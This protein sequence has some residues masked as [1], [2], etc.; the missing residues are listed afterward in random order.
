MPSR[1]EPLAVADFTGGLNLGGDPFQLAQNESPDLLNVEL[2]SQ[3]GLRSREGWIRWNTSA[4]TADTWT[5]KA[6]RRF[7]AAS[8]NRYVML[9]NGTKILFTSE[10]L[11]WAAMQTGDPAVDVVTTAP[12]GA[13]FIEWNNSLYVVPGAA[14]AASYEWTGANPAVALTESGTGAWQDS[15]VTPVGGHMPKADFACPHAGYAFVAATMENGTLY[16]NRLRWSH[17]NSPENWAEDDYIDILDGGDGITAL[18]PFG[19]HLLIFK[20]TSLWAL[21]GS[22][23]DTWQLVNVTRQI[24]TSRQTMVAQSEDAVWIFDWPQGLFKYSPNEGIRD[25]FVPLRGALADGSISATAVQAGKAYVNFINRRLWVS[26]PYS[27]NSVASEVTRAFVFDPRLGPGGAWLSHQTADG[28]GIGSAVDFLSSS[29]Q[30]VT[31]A[32]HPTQKYVL[33]VEKENEPTDA[34][35]AAGQAFPSHY[36]TSWYTSGV[37]TQ[38]KLWRRADFITKRQSGTQQ[39]T[40]QVFKDYDERSPSRRFLVDLNTF[41]GGAWGVGTWGVSRFWGVTGDSNIIQR[42]S[43]MGQARSIQLRISAIAGVPWSVNAIVFKFVARRF[44]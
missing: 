39:L 33:Q 40:V 31:L 18:V 44:R 43:M 38:Q 8:G 22:D 17:P 6:L 29:E 24:G 26:L 37:P 32:V 42:G 10:G 23:A 9:C 4:I 11:T 16:K 12:H 21:Y 7:Y 3:G 14:A 30:R 15:Y 36:T 28:Y 34:I 27:Q 1:L 2:D 35:T 25:L 19:D 41:T 20:R 13:S 5:P